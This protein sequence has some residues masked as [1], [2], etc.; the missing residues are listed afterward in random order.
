L[1][2]VRKRLAL[3]T[4][5]NIPRYII[6]DAEYPCEFVSLR[7]VD[8]YQREVLEEV[9]GNA[10]ELLIG[11]VRATPHHIGKDIVPAFPGSGLFQEQGRS[12]T[13]AAYDLY[14][15]KIRIRIGSVHLPRPNA[16]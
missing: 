11:S 8:V 6:G 14:S 15:F 1:S 16:D 10:G 7:R 3:P 4:G 9:L 13:P 5:N 2:E 12:V